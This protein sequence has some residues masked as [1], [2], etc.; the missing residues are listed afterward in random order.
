MPTTSL[1]RG[2]P[3]EAWTGKR[4]SISHFRIF[5]CEAYALV[6]KK[7]RKKLDQKSEKCYFVGYCENISTYRLYNP[8]TK[9]IKESREVTF[10]EIMPL[11]QG[12]RLVI[13][14]DVVT[15]TPNA[16]LLETAQ[17]SFSHSQEKNDRISLE[18][19]LNNSKVAS[20]QQEEASSDEVRRQS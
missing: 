20:T 16:T 2:T 8:V 4:P 3:Y 14:G 7:L 13:E 15:S 1:K 12:R 5:G 10:H 9:K 6:P 11:Q 19:V 18:V 17:K